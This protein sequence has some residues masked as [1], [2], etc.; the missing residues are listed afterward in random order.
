MPPVL[1]SH[2]VMTNTSSNKNKNQKIKETTL[3]RLTM[4]QKDRRWC[5]I[6]KPDVVCCRR[7]RLREETRGEREERER[8]SEGVRDGVGGGW[9][10]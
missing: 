10:R 8:V 3:L 9:S 4:Y 2:L 6:R 7:M 1:E 5:L